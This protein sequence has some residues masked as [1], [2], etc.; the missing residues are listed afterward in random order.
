MSQSVLAATI[1]ISQTEWLKQ[2][3]HI[4]HSSGGEKT[5][6]KSLTDLVSPAALVSGD[7]LLGVHSQSSSCNLTWQKGARMGSLL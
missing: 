4:S 1:K 7:D 5:K 3:T 6:T 2:Q